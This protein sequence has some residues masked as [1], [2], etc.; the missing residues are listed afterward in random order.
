MRNRKEIEGGLPGYI[1]DH[2]YTNKIDEVMRQLCKGDSERCDEF[3]REV[4][5]WSVLKNTASVTVSGAT[6]YVLKYIELNHMLLVEGRQEAQQRTFF[7]ELAHMV[8]QFL[9][10]ERGHGKPWKMVFE[11]LGFDPTILHTHYTYSDVYTS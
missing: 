6:H 7:H 3:W 2:G 5:V 4:R 9:W 11:M 10:D 1:V 8:A